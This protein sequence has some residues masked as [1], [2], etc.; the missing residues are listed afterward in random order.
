MS[1]ISVLTVNYYRSMTDAEKCW[2][3]WKC[4]FPTSHIYQS[5][6]ARESSSS[7][8]LSPAQCDI[9][10]LHSSRISRSRV[11]KDDLQ[12]VE[13]AG[14]GWCGSADSPHQNTS[15]CWEWLTKPLLDNEPQQGRRRPGH[16]HMWAVRGGARL[17]WLG[18]LF[19]AAAVAHYLCQE[20]KCVCACGN[21]RMLFCITRL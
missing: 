11:I 14:E 2:E 10:G 4:D 15:E 17:P 7:Q 20:I 21:V 6:S 3:I 13:A 5:F 12:S 19:P 1:D 9:S 16:V 8:C 18:T